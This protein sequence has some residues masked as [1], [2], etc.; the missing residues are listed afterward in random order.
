MNAVNQRAI[1]LAE[2]SNHVE[3]LQLTLCPVPAL[4]SHKQM[5]GHVLGLAN[6]SGTELVFSLLDIVQR[7]LHSA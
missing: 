5:I 2:N 6:P 3:L 1:P 7:H 4:R